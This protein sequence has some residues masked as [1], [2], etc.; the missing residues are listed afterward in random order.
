MNDAEILFH[1]NEGANHYISLFG[2]AKHMERYDAGSYSFVRPKPGEAG[3]HFIYN[4][5]VEELEPAERYSV[6]QEIH[7]SG[8]P[9]WLDLMASDDVFALFFGKDKPHGQTEFAF[10]DEQYL[11]MHP[12][13]FI[14]QPASQHIIEVRTPEEFALWAELANDLLADG[15]MDIHPIHHFTLVE[16]R[17]MRCYM[18]YVDGQPISIAAS[19]N[20]RGVVSLELVAT[21][22]EH[23]RH[24]YAREVCA[25][26]IQDAID[27]HCTLLTVRANSSASASLY[28]SLGFQVY[29]HAL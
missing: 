17:L 9:F 23:R 20:N 8:M 15:H 13:Q 19:M 10:D 27:A 12:V 7:A 29:N 1:I 22:P 25:K 28:H 6:A 14:N 16:R 18:L 5:R 4:I 3:I 2:E 11:A 24:G 21:L 26:A